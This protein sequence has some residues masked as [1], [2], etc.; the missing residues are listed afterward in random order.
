MLSTLRIGSYARSSAPSPASTGL[1]SKL[2][3]A[4]E[5]GGEVRSLTQPEPVGGAIYDDNA[6]E[7]RHPVEQHAGERSGADRGPDFTG[8][9]RRALLRVARSQLRSWPPRGLAARA[10]CRARERRRGPADAFCSADPIPQ[11]SLA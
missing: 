3:F 8:S 9:V 11:L 10:R 6:I 4:A 1:A 5:V 7:C 2:P